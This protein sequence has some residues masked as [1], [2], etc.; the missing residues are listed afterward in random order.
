MKIKARNRP[1]RTIKK[2]RI[3]TGHHAPFDLD[4]K[5]NR[6]KSIGQAVRYGAVLTGIYR[7]AQ[8]RTTLKRTTHRNAPY[9]VRKPK[10]APYRTAP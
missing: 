1:H 9:V 10:S 6:E 8:H 4:M 7:P 3:L 2:N 5:R